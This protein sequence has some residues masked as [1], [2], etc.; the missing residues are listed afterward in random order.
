MS[1]TFTLKQALERCPMDQCTLPHKSPSREWWRYGWAF[2]FLGRGTALLGEQVRRK[3][4]R[5]AM[6]AGQQAG[7]HARNEH[8]AGK[9]SA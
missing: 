4:Y 3:N 1:G 7:I 9:V 5:V 2:G 8:N 6:L